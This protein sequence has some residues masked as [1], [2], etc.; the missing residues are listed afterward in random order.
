MLFHIHYSCEFNW[1][2]P[3]VFLVELLDLA[4]SY[5]SNP[6]EI[7]VV[8]DHT[9]WGKYFEMKNNWNMDP[10]YKR[11]KILHTTLYVNMCTV[12]CGEGGRG[13]S[14]HWGHIMS[15]FGGEVSQVH[16]RYIKIALNNPKSTVD[17]PS[18]ILWSPMHSWYPQ[19]TDEH[20]KCIAQL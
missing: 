6:Q 18:Q 11:G 3:K 8:C 20:L 13:C 4:L 7:R 19:W 10:Y 17:I 15:A 9:G 1:I 16:W 12:Y 5:S 14:V 2:G